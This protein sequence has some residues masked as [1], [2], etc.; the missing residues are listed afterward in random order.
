MQSNYKPIGDY[1]R[2]VDVRN[3][4]LSV[5]TLLGLTVD[6]VF[7]PSVANTIGTNMANYK[8]I[9]KGQFACSL[10]QVR[11]DK[12]IPV[13]LLSDFN[14]AIIS[15][16]YPTFEVTDHNQLDPEYLMMWFSR[17]EFDRESCFYAI[18][19]VRGSLEWEDFCNMALPIP[20]IETQRKIVAQY[21]IIK[22]R[23]ALKQSINKNL[24]D[25]A[26]AMFKS[27]FVDFDPVHKLAEYEAG[28]SPYTT[29]KDLAQSLYMDE[30]TLN[31]FSTTFNEN[32]F[33]M[34]WKEKSLGNLGDISTGKTPSTAKSEYYGND[35]PFLTIP[36]MHNKIFSVKTNKML[37]FEGEKSQKN[38]T[39]PIGSI[40]F[41]CIATPGLTT[42]LHRPM[43]TNQQINTLIPEKL[44]I[45][46][47]LYFALSKLG[48][49]TKGK[50]VGAVFENM[51]KTEFSQIEILVPTYEI[52]L[53]FSDIVK[54][55]LDTIL[56]NEKEIQI[57][58]KTLD[59]LLSNLTNSEKLEA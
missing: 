52:A 15:Q 13:A 45:S 41:S 49:N 4:E 21:N 2:L 31:Q 44:E 48:E 53:Y 40:A 23:I 37:S 34:G 47:Y 54:S 12:K 59:T 18:G 39:M 38:K 43:Q 20:D 14:E 30:T 26:Q 17:K 46:N 33:P 50:G 9:R 22:D 55:K 29:K 42:L 11:R 27:W 8:I 7:I 16:A 6:K 51:N 35:I 36:D 56:N 24:E 5:N 32:D 19:G 10:M 3:T 25:M 28:N 1:I 58:T 57:L